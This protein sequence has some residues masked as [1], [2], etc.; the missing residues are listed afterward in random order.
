[1]LS[2]T[3]S[4][5]VSFEDIVSNSAHVQAARKSAQQAA[6]M[7]H[8]VLIVGE[9]GTEKEMFAAAIHG[10]SS[11]ADRPFVELDCFY[12]SGTLIEEVLFGRQVEKELQPTMKSCCGGTLF[13][14]DVGALPLVAQSRITHAC[15]S[16]KL[17]LDSGD[18]MDFTCRIVASTV[19][20]LQPVV[21]DRLFR[22]DLHQMLSQTMIW[23]PPLRHRKED[24]PLLVHRFIDEY[25]AS[26]NKPLNSISDEAMNALVH[27][28]WPGNVRELKTVIGR[29]AL[30]A[31]GEMILTDHLPKAIQ[32]VRK[33]KNVPVQDEDALS[34]ATIEKRHI[35]KVL[36]YTGWHK[37][38]SAKILGIDRSTLYDKIRR[39][40]LMNPADRTVE[41]ASI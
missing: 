23:L 18:E 3:K 30:L 5:T 33:I 14:Q 24:V 2:A 19:N 34:L 4:K 8:H 28:P 32:R 35:Q 13:I 16:G 37:V 6:L 7:G 41:P 25:A 10:A 39:Y 12:L 31:K 40:N 22:A 26:L 38:R 27:Y 17:A 11:R 36:D 20:D 1:M 21:E 9:Q 29:C 15:Q